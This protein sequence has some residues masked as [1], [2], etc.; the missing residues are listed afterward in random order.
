MKEAQGKTVCLKDYQSP[1]FIIEE[2]N[3]CFQLFEDK[4]LVRSRLLFRRSPQAHVDAQNELVLD[5]RDL[6]LEKVSLDG[7]VLDASAYEVTEESLVIA[8][9]PDSFTLEC[10]TR[11]M[12]QDNTSL[13]DY[14]NPE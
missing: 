14:T 5:G 9:V 13:K 11:I 10:E 3:L 8:Q 1:V 6:H 2:T 4:T 7:N 12:P